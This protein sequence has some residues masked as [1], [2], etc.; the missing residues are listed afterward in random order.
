MLPKRVLSLPQF[1]PYKDKP[2][3]VIQ[4]YDEMLDEYYKV[5]E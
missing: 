3:C 5:R 2:R 4:D 1:G